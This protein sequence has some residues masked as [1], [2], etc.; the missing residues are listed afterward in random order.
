[1][2]A[3]S[4]SKGEYRP[5][6]QIARAIAVLCVLLFHLGVPPFKGGFI[7]V[8][9]FFV[10][11]GYFITR[12]LLGG[13]EK[14]GK[15][16]ILAF[17]NRRV[18]RILPL[19]LFVCF[20]CMALAP[21][22]LPTVEF[23]E[24]TKQALA[25]A[26][27]FP[28]IFWRDEN[29]FIQTLFRPLLHFWSLGVEYHYYLIFPFLFLAMQKWKWADLFF[30][31]LS[32]LLCLYLTV[33]SP[34]A[35]FYWVPMRVWE[36]MFGYY[37]FRYEGKINFRAPFTHTVV[38]FLSVGAILATALFYDSGNLFPAWALPPTL[39]TFF[40]IICGLP[41]AKGWMKAPSAILVWIGTI[42]FSIYLWH[43][44]VIWAFTYEPF[45]YF[46][47]PP[48]VQVPL[49][50]VLTLGL[51]A[52][53][54]RFV[55][56]PFRS[57]KSVSD[58][59]FYRGVAGVFALMICMGIF[60]AQTG[61]SVKN[62]SPAQ[63][64]AMTAVDDRLPYRCDGTKRDKTKDYKS[65]LLGNVPPQPGKNVLLVGDS[66]ADSI[67]PAFISGAEH[68]NVALYLWGDNCNPGENGCET[69]LYPKEIALRHIT[70]FVFHGFIENERVYRVLE[71]ILI[72]LKDTAVRV[73][74]IDQTPVFDRSV[75]TSVY[76]GDEPILTREDYRAQNETYFEWK[77]SIQQKFPKTRFYSVEP[78]LCPDE[79]LKIKN[80]HV[81]YFDNHHLN[82]SGAALLAP[83]VTEIY[84]FRNI[85]KN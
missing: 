56:V 59:I 52:L 84:G 85:S 73:H 57:K 67:K 68:N 41:D 39:A 8:D 43:Y 77:K 37:A 31:G 83:I 32:F 53:S 40:L 80:E 30:F 47:K 63:K 28:N 2:T 23:R 76:K 54:Y 16:E 69:A 19:A 48:L 78:I 50:I 18:R 34:K 5:D 45:V 3:L 74:I 65:C 1:M 60:Y 24:I 58:K 9:V 29:Y 22:L 6:L 62:Y 70:D 46:P 51:S 75:P 4:T 42:S 44:P 25:S 61:Y 81:L 71:E 10:L 55:E 38:S 7:G 20:L 21:F 79:C 33:D 12:T 14:I 15:G 13:G 36:F 11:S 27:G 82:V 35:A 49:I 66:H 17:Y 64:M 72:S 26:F